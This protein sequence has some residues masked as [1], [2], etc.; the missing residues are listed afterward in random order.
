MTHY[1][2]FMTLRENV[3][4]NLLHRYKIPPQCNVCEE[5]LSAG[6]EVVRKRSNAKSRYYHIE[7][8]KKVNLL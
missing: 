1:I 6:T 7:C 8:A 4:L 2:V 5:E 3:I